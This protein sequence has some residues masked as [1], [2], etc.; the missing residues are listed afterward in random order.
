MQTL[1]SDSP[2]TTS[3]RR[4]RNHHHCYP[5]WSAGG[6]VIFIRVNLATRPPTITTDVS[7]DL[8]THGALA[9]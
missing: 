3:S 9:N 4:H 8:A 6:V 7:V 1:N 2:A 5:R